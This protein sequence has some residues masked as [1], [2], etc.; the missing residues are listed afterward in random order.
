MS[1]PS[2]QSDTGVNVSWVIILTAI[3]VLGLGLAFF[4]IASREPLGLIEK[5]KVEAR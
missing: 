1:E 4:V 3:I 2:D 5:P